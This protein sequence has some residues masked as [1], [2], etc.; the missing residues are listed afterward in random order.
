MRDIKEGR[1]CWGIH[2]FTETRGKSLKIVAS[3]NSDVHEATNPVIEGS[4][5]W[6]LIFFALYIFNS[7]Q[8]T[9][10]KNPTERVYLSLSS[11]YLEWLKRKLPKHPLHEIN[12]KEI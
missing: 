2:L 4:Y 10:M 7:F 1:F 12:K 11:L 6:F 5:M 3:L 9:I 8:N